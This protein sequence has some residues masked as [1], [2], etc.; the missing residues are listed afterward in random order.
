LIANAQKDGCQHVFY[1]DSEGGA[2]T[3]FFENAG[4]DPSTIEQI[5]VESVEDAQIKILDTFNLIL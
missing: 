3:K 1:F 2:G 4:C 5:L